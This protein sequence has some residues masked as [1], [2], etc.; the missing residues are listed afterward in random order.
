[1]ANIT[2]RKSSDTLAK[3]VKAIIEQV[4]HPR[5]AGRTAA[6]AGATTVASA[7]ATTVLVVAGVTTVLPTGATTVEVPA[8]AV[9]GAAIGTAVSKSGAGMPMAAAA[10]SKL[11]PL[12]A[13]V[14]FAMGGAVS[15]RRPTARWA[16]FSTSRFVRPV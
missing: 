14:A 6:A 12:S 7:G 1:M 5:V 13:R 4:D 9:I 3:L 16:S 8:E 11:Y 2:A 15:S 10:S